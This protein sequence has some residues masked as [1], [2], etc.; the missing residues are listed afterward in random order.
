MHSR[1]TQ[2]VLLSDVYFDISIIAEQ[3][4]VLS[5]S[6]IQPVRDK[7]KDAFTSFKFSCHVSQRFQ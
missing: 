1:Q 4:S 6:M 5:I 3:V 7:V 2:G